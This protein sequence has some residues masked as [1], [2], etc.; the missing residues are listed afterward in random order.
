VQP[1]SGCTTGVVMSTGVMMYDQSRDV[2]PELECTT[3][4]MMCD[5]SQ[6]VYLHCKNVQWV[7]YDMKKLFIVSN[8]IKG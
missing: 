2:Q 3:G 5:W 6:A 7:V 8:K 1:E 4:V